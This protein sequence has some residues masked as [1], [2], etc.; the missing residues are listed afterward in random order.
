MTRNENATKT[1]EAAEMEHDSKDV[2]TIDTIKSFFQEVSRQ[3]EMVLNKAVNPASLVT[4]QRTDK[5]SSDITV[6][7][8]KLIK[9][10]NDVSDVQLSIEASQEMEEEKNKKFEERIGK[11]KNKEARNIMRR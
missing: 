1:K 8:K 10:A 3:Q 6:N 9:L 4:N 7:N 5:L 11:E 2:I